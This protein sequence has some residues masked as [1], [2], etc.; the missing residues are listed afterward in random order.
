MWGSSE[1]ALLGLLATD[2]NGNFRPE[3][4]AEYRRGSNVE[5]L[6]KI[7]GWEILIFLVALAATIVF[8]LM[9]GQINTDGLLR[10]K[11]GDA[12]GKL[13]PERVQL[14]VAT[15]GAAMYYVLQVSTN[16]N[17]GTLPDVPQTWPAMLGGSNLLYLGGKAYSRFFGNS[18]SK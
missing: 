4:K 1:A 3:A 9:T 13:S 6:V 16:P 2:L 11:L 17:S 7:I 5:L 15:L 12:R 10:T 14:L 18:N 8:Q